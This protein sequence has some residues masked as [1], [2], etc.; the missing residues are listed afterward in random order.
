M[1]DVIVVDDLP[2]HFASWCWTGYLLLSIDD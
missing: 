2:Q 1:M